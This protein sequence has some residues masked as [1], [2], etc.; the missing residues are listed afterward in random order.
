[1]EED[2]LVLLPVADFVKFVQNHKKVSFKYKSLWLCH[3]LLKNWIFVIL[4]FYQTMNVK[5]NFIF[6]NIGNYN[7]N[8]LLLHRNF[9]KK[10]K[11]L[12][13]S[14]TVLVTILLHSQYSLTI[15]W[16]VHVAILLQSPYRTENDGPTLTSYVHTVKQYL[17]D[18][19]LS[20]I[21]IGMEK[22]FR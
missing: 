7:Y 19:I 3:I 16:T 21:V 12:A 18:S 1:M 4:W 10:K 9:F 11:K 15:L 14:L 17:P 13:T 6:E 2:V 5:F 22:Y 8:Y 20:F